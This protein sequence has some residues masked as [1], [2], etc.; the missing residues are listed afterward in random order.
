[1]ISFARSGQ[2][3]CGGGELAEVYFKQDLKPV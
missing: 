1:M 2:G 3:T